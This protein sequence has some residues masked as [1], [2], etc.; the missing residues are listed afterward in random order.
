MDT[1]TTLGADGA[2]ALDVLESVM[3]CL[4][5]QDPAALPDEEKAR[6]LRVLERVDAVEAAVRG[7]LL[8][9]F[10]AQNCSVADGQRTTR[11]WLVHTTR[12]TTGQAAEHKA[13]QAL[14][15]RHPRLAAALADGHV[16]TRSQ[17]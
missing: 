3:A 4:A 7:R 16:L 2:D 11:A 9:A 17:A 14:A 1:A 15:E 10:D 5:V 13:V 8:A 12:V 6:R